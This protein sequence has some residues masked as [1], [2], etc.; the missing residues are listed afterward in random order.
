TADTAEPAA[1]ERPPREVNQGVNAALTG[2]PDIVVRR[3]RHQCLE[4]RLERGPALEIEDAIES[5][6]AVLRL[7]Q[8]Q[9]ASLVGG[10]GLSQRGPP[11]DPTL[12]ALGDSSEAPRV[13]G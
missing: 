2:R 3:G 4:R 5:D 13:H 9:K 8:V 6:H 7:A 10:V 12:E 11:I 1:I